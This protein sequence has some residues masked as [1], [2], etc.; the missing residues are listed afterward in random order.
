MSVEF[1]SVSPQHEIS[2]SAVSRKRKTDDD[3]SWAN[4]EKSRTLSVTSDT[5]HNPTLQ[6]SLLANGRKYGS[7]SAKSKKIKTLSESDAFQN[8]PLKSSLSAKGQKGIYHSYHIIIILVSN[9]MS[10]E[11]LTFSKA[12]RNRLQRKKMT[13]LESKYCLQT[14]PLPNFAIPSN[15]LIVKISEIS[16]AHTVKFTSTVDAQKPK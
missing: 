2:H 7:L 3:N 12:V 11:K 16:S 4:P 5:S 9:I 13:P 8:Q 14:R 10:T 15:T 6:S 1:E